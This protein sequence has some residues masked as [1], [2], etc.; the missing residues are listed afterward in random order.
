M[1]LTPDIKRVKRFEFICM[2]DLRQIVKQYTDIC[3]IRFRGCLFTSKRR[4]DRER[5]LLKLKYDKC[6]PPIS[7]HSNYAETTVCSV[8]L[9]GMQDSSY[10]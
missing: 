7:I 1:P 2:K 3:F 6:V 4:V 8:L 5:F 10:L 9:I